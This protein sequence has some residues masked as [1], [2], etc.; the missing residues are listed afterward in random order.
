MVLKNLR[1][2]YVGGSVVPGSLTRTRFLAFRAGSAV[3]VAG[4]TDPDASEFELEAT[5]QSAAG[6]FLDHPPTVMLPDSSSSSS[7]CDGVVTL[8]SEPDFGGD[9]VDVDMSRCSLVSLDRGH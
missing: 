9:C 2:G 8:C 4:R 5:G 7:S 3:A 1:L 6:L